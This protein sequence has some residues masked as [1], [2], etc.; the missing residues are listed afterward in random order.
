[1]ARKQIRIAAPMTTFAS[2]VSGALISL[3]LF[4]LAPLPLM[5]AGADN[6][7]GQ[8]TA[9]TISL[10]GWFSGAGASHAGIGEF[11]EAG[12]RCTAARAA[13]MAERDLLRGGID[14]TFGRALGSDFLD[15]H[16]RR[17]RS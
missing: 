10:I 16:L 6:T 13:A 4:Y 11:E 14:W 9:F 1:M 3:V 15:D 8:R 17:S 7:E 5:V 2:I 12:W